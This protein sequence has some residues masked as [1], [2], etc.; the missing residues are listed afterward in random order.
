MKL[1]INILF[2]VVFSFPMEVFGG[3][4]G[5]EEFIKGYWGKMPNEFGVLQGRPD[6]DDSFPRFFEINNAGHIYISDVVNDVIHKYDQSG[7]L[8]V[9]IASPSAYQK[10]WDIRQVDDYNDNVYVHPNGGV[11]VQC[12]DKYLFFG[13]DDNLLTSINASNFNGFVIVG[14]NGFYFKMSSDA[15]KYKLYSVEGQYVGM[16][17]D[18]QLNWPVDI[19]TIQNE[20]HIRYPDN[21]TYRIALNKSCQNYYRDIFKTFYLIESGDGDYFSRNYLVHRQTACNQEDMV[22][23]MPRTRFDQNRPSKKDLT[24]YFNWKPSVI[25]EY[26]IPVVSNSGDIYCWARTKTDYKILKWTWQG[27]ATAPQTLKA[28]PSE[29]SISLSWEPPREEAKSVTDYE[30]Y[31]ASKVCGPFSAL[32]KVKKDV[33]Q[34]EDKDLKNGDLF[35]FQIR[36]IRGKDYS[37]Y[38][39]KVVGKVN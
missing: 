11:V 32:A 3:W 30:I 8:V 26:G 20:F 39:N 13:K 9:V 18:S 5:P 15:K 27:E 17:E 31:R 36:A 21:Q 35:Y 14:E 29:K 37:G 38:S 10:C 22:L 28:S 6:K 4:I 1:V 25:V 12:L 24:A 33:F 2:L 23:E 16:F 7:K 34:Y 19:S